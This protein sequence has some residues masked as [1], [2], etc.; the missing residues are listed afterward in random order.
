MRKTIEENLDLSTP[1]AVE[2]Y[3][4][5]LH[6]ILSKEAMDAKKILEKSNALEFQKINDEFHMIE[7]QTI[8]VY[9]PNVENRALLDQLREGKPT[10]AVCVPWD[11]AQ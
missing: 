10:R 6:F 2:A 5:H 3:F 7:S 9:I 4:R 11:G 8:P 1:Q